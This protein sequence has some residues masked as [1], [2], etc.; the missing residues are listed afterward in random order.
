MTWFSTWHQHGRPHYRAHPHETAAAE[1]AKTM[2]ANGTPATHFW[3][4]ATKESA[5]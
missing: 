2:Q 1:H 5:P 4:E 3:S